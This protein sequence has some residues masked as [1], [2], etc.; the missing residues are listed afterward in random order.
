MKDVATLRDLPEDIAKAL[1]EAIKTQAKDLIAHLPA[2]ERD[3]LNVFELSKLFIWQKTPEGFPFW[4]KV[5]ADH[6]HIKLRTEDL[7]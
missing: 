4:R 6:K 7:C 5:A 2:Y 3:N 1:R